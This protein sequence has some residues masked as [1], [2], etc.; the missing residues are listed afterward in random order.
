[1]VQM[2]QNGTFIATGFDATELALTNTQTTK[3]ANSTYTK[4]TKRLG[5]YFVASNYQ[6]NNTIDAST[7][8]GIITLFYLD[9]QMNSL[10][11][12]DDMPGLGEFVLIGYDSPP[13]SNI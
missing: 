6:Y 11:G 3:T 10:N 8:S 12:G 1:M 4:I 13:N 5:D 9:Y 7:Q 2:L